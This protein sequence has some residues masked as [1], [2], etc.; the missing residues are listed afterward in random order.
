MTRASA[1]LDGPP[2]L[3]R[4]AAQNRRLLLD[5]AAQVFAVRGLDAGVEEIAK[6]A[7]VGVGT[8][9]RRFPTKDALIAE[10]VKDVL[11]TMRQLATAATQ[12]ADGSGLE[13][14][15]ESS[16]AYQAAHIGCLPRLWNTDADNQTVRE[17]RRIIADLLTEAQRHGMM[18]AELTSTDI[19]MVM[20]SIRGVIE[21]TRGIAPDAW[22]RQ[23]D[24]LLAGLRP[25][26]QPLSHRPLTRAA[27]DRILADPALPR[28]LP[29]PVS[30]AAPSLPR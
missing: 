5:A 8:L 23:L 30:E 25:A 14:F 16:C 20:W 17:V 7:G 19:T 18:R 11:A 3:R 1:V 13:R 28:P 24:I 29:R 21:T 4:D 9:Y 12:H 6:V 10:L 2:P 15:L 27:V 22:R 26:A